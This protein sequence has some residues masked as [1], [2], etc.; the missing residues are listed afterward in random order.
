MPG[1]KVDL[2]KVPLAHAPGDE[3]TEGLDGLA[4]RFV[5]YKKQ[6]ARAAKW[7]AVYNITA[8]LPSRLAIEAECGLARALRRDRAGSGHRADRRTGSVDGRRPRS[9]AAPEV[10]EVV[11]EVFVAL[12]R[13]R[14]VLEHSC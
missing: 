12:Q 8:N 3:I 4:R 14:V 5:D 7:R 9:S 13:H 10:I 11:Y 6:G 2:G 1:I